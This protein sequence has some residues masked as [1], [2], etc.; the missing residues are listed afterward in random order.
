[1][2]DPSFDSIFMRRLRYL[3]TPQWDIYISLKDRLKGATVLEI[4]SGTGSGTL[5]YASEAKSVDAIELDRH[6]VQFASE[7][8]PAKNIRWICTDICHWYTSERY[9]YEVA[10]ETME[11]IR[12]W[13]AA[14][15]NIHEFLAPG[16][17]FIMSARNA[18]SDLRRWKDLHER[19][20]TARQLVSSLG[21]F[22]PEV[23]LYDYSLTLEQDEDTRMTPLVAVARKGP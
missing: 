19:E 1:M 16:G 13:Y 6:A 5:L 15:R 12:N 9:D 3:L 18:N 21:E 23:H 22:F 14:L 10:I 17:Y 20:L 7:M 8:F 2:T 11:N 4:G